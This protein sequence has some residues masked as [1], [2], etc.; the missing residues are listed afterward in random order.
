MTGWREEEEEEVEER[1]V[2]EV[3]SE[4]LGE[5][6]AGLIAGFDAAT[7]PERT[8]HG[9]PTLCNV[10]TRHHDGHT[11]WC[12]GSHGNLETGSTP[13]WRRREKQWLMVE[14]VV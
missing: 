11:P 10:C 2:E 5:E 9:S 13:S 3:K 7:A 1:E 8:E 14:H 6:A 12:T 4:R